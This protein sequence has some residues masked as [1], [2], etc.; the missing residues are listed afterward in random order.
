MVNMELGQELTTRQLTRF[1]RFCGLETYASAKYSAI[2]C[3]RF[4]Q[5]F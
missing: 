3:F 4:F 5:T 2:D 1:L